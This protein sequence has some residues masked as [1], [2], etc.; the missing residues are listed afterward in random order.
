MSEKFIISN[1]R[2]NAIYK[3]FLLSIINHLEHVT[4]WSSAVNPIVFNVNK[5]YSGGPMYPNKT[6]FDRKTLCGKLGVI[7]SCEKV[8][9]MLIEI[10]RMII[11]NDYNDILRYVQEVEHEYNLTEISIDDITHLFY[12]DDDDCEEEDRG[13]SLNEESV[14]ELHKGP[15]IIINPKEMDLWT[16]PR[17]RDYIAK[18]HAFGF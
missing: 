12:N 9:N 2:N 5:I 14:I 16:L 15:D 8:G 6:L 18:R 10:L 4:Y 17:I 13:L 7:A 11:D 1:L 3:Y